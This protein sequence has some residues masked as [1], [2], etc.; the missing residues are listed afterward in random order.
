M[1]AWAVTAFVTGPGQ[2]VWHAK[3][4]AF[5]DYVGFVA[6]D[7]WCFDGAFFAGAFKD[8]IAHGCVEGFG[9][10]WV[11]IAGRI[12]GMSAIVDIATIEG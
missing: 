10:V 11:C 8:G 12:V 7:E 4:K 2:L 9:A 6:L 3:A 5:A 1:A